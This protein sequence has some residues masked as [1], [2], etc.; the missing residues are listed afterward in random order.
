MVAFVMSAAAVEAADRWFE[1]AEG[2]SVLRRLGDMPW[3]LFNQNDIDRLVALGVPAPALHFGTAGTYLLRTLAEGMGAV[4]DAPPQGGSGVFA[5][6]KSQRDYATLAAAA[7]AL[8]APLHVVGALEHAALF[9]GVEGVTFQADLDVT[10]FHRAMAR[11]RVV[12]VPIEWT[13]SSA[14]HLTISAAQ[15]M[16]KPVVATRVPGLAGYID[17]GQNGILVPP[18][19]PGA[20]AQAIRALL[21]DDA[22]AH[23]LG[24]AGR[25]AELARCARF[26]DLLLGLAESALRARIEEDAPPLEEPPLETHRAAIPVRLVL[27]GAARP[28]DEGGTTTAVPAAPW[29]LPAGTPDLPPPGGIDALRAY[30]RSGA[31]RL[32]T[33]RDVRVLATQLFE[34]AAYEALLSEATTTGASRVHCLHAL[35]YLWAARFAAAEGFG[36]DSRVVDVGCGVG[37]GCA[38]LRR[39]FDDVTGLDFDPTAI[40]LARR[41]WGAALGDA[42]RLVVADL[43]ALTEAPSPWAGGAR[44]VTC[45]ECVEHLV[46][47]VRGVRALRHLMAPDGLLLASV[48]F[49]SYRF[50]TVLF[51]C[52][53]D[54]VRLAKTAFRDVRVLRQEETGRIGAA[55]ALAAPSSYL[56]V[57]RA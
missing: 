16:G 3:I 56:L 35:R 1:Q 28:P 34:E 53:E 55:R 42:S 10:A 15:M 40:D 9:Q 33:G 29:L 32:H 51:T 21:D 20:L 4:L 41:L 43:L 25:A 6:G 54:A 2:E 11:A 39:A 18:G 57:C 24:E 13:E 12:V 36:R 52:E 5:G 17:H 37:Y 26:E 50:H 49:N 30:D 22:L 8:G 19:E 14:G 7:P 27:A 45:F 48:P 46:D 47:P 31:A 44:L 38:I 23:R